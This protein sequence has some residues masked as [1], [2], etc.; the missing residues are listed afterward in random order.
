MLDSIS[1]SRD[2]IDRHFETGSRLRSVVLLRY[3]GVIAEGTGILVQCVELTKVNYLRVTLLV[4]R[5][6]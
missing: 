1:T 3:S 6:V 2:K 5:N 4:F